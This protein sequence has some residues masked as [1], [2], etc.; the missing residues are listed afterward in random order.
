[1]ERIS[2]PRHPDWQLFDHSEP[3]TAL[4]AGLS[5]GGEWFDHQAAPRNSTT[6]APTARP[7]SC[8]GY[9]A[10]CGVPLDRMTGW[11][12]G[13]K[14]KA[15]KSSVRRTR[16]VGLYTHVQSP[17][18]KGSS[19]SHTPS[20]PGLG[21]YGE[22]LWSFEYSA[23]R[24]P[25]ERDAE[26]DTTTGYCYFGGTSGQPPSTVPLPPVLFLP[27][28]FFLA[29]EDVK[30][31]ASVCRSLR[32][33]AFNR[34]IWQSLCF[35][36]K[37][38]SHPTCPRAGQRRSDGTKS[39]RDVLRLPG[40][41]YTSYACR[42]PPNNSKSRRD[43]NCLR[44]YCPSTQATKQQR[45]LRTIAGEE[46][47][48]S[49]PNSEP[50]YSAWGLRRCEGPSP[51]LY[52]VGRRSWRPKQET[53][54]ESDADMQYEP[55]E[56]GVH[57]GGL[58]VLPGYTLEELVDWRFVF[59]LN[60]MSPGPKIYIR[61][62]DLELQF[63]MH[64]V[65][66]NVA[67]ARRH[68]TGMEASAVQ[69]CACR[70]VEN[71]RQARWG[72]RMHWL[73][74]HE[75]VFIFIRRAMNIRR[76]MRL[77]HLRPGS[78]PGLCVAE[79]IRDQ[80]YLLEWQ[81]PLHCL[82]EP[83][84]H[85]APFAVANGGPASPLVWPLPPY[86]MRERDKECWLD[87][88]SVIY[89]FLGSDQEEP[90]LHAPEADAEYASRP[91][92]AVLDSG[93]AFATL[94]APLSYRTAAVFIALGAFFV[95]VATASATAT[96]TTAAAATATLAARHSRIFRMNLHV[97][98]RDEHEEDQHERTEREASPSCLLP[99][100]S[101]SLA[102]EAVPAPG[103]AYDCH[104][105][106]ANEAMAGRPR[107]HGGSF[108][109]A[110]LNDVC[111]GGH[112]GKRESDHA[113][114]MLPYVQG[115]IPARIARL[116]RSSTLASLA[117]TDA[118]VASAT[119]VLTAISR[120]ALTATCAALAAA[121]AALTAMLLPPGAAVRASA[122]DSQQKGSFVFRVR[123]AGKQWLRHR[124]VR[125][126][127]SL[128]LRLGA[129]AGGNAK[130]STD[131]SFCM[132]S[133]HRFPHEGREQQHRPR[134]P[135]VC[136]LRQ[137]GVSQDSLLDGLSHPTPSQVCEP[138]RILHASTEACPRHSN[139][140]KPIRS[141]D[142]CDAT[143]AFEFTDD[144]E[145]IV[146]RSL[147]DGHKKSP[148]RRSL[149]QRR[150]SS[151]CCPGQKRAGRTCVVSSIEEREE[152][153]RC[154]RMHYGH[155]EECSA[156][157]VSACTGEA[158][159]QS[160]CLC[161]SGWQLE[162]TFSQPC[163]G[164]LLFVNTCLPRVNDV[165]CA[166]GLIGCC[167]S[168]ADWDALTAA[169]SIA[170]REDVPLLLP[171]DAT[172]SDLV[173][174]LFL[175]LAQRNY[176]LPLVAAART[177]APATGSHLCNAAG[178]SVCLR[179]SRR[180]GRSTSAARVPQRAHL[181][182]WLAS[183]Q[184]SGDHNA[185]QPMPSAK[186]IGDLRLM[187][188][189]R[190][191]LTV[192]PS[193][194]GGLSGVAHTR[195]LT[196]V[197]GPEDPVR[198]GEAPRLRRISTG[199]IERGNPLH[200]YSAVVDYSATKSLSSRPAS[201][202]LLPRSV[203]AQYGTLGVVMSNPNETE[204]VLILRREAGPGLLIQ[205]PK[206]RI[207]AHGGHSPVYSTPDDPEITPSFAPLELDSGSANRT[208]CSHF[209]HG[210]CARYSLN[211][212]ATASENRRPG[213]GSER[214]EGLLQSDVKFCKPWILRSSL[215]TRQFEY[216]PQRMNVM[217]TGTNDGT[218]CLLDW[219]KDA[220][221][222][223]KLVDSHQIL[224]LSWL[225]HHP[226]LFV[227]A[228]GVSGIPYVL[229]CTEQDD[230]F[231]SGMET[232]PA[233]APSATLP[234]CLTLP[235][236]HAKYKQSALHQE[237]I[238]EAQCAPDK[239]SYYTWDGE[240]I[241]DGST[242]TAALTWFRHCGRG[243]QM[244]RRDTEP[245]RIVHQYCACEELSS[246]TINSTDDYMLVSGR[247]PDI[248]IHDVATGV[249]L[250]TLSGLHAGS[251]N[252]VRFAHTSPHL[253]VTASFDQTCRL[254]DLRQRISG[255]QPLLNVETGSLSV[256]CCFDDSDEWLLCS[257][258][259]AALRQVCL[260][261]SEVYPESFAIPPVNAETNFRRAVYL[262]GGREFITAGTEEGFF[263][264]FSRCGRDLG[265]VSLEGMLRPFARLRSSQS[266][267]TM[268]ILACD[269]L[270]LRTYLRSHVELGLTAMGGAAVAT[271]AGV[272]RFSMAA[273]LRRAFRHLGGR[274]PEISDTAELLERTRRTVGESQGGLCISREGPMQSLTDM[275]QEDAARGA[276]ERCAVEE[277]VQSLRAHPQE[278]RL[279][280]TLLAAKDQVETAT[281]KLSFVAMSRLPSRMLG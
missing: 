194:F 264:V 70:D 241:F 87:E 169:S 209:Q 124:F 74:P 111:T 27:V 19:V 163:H 242:M 91:F 211:Q 147:S 33:I 139:C 167:G 39:S 57:C 3:I 231:V 215:N 127:A 230:S 132:R 234:S 152:C 76:P 100:V 196:L 204:P 26:F 110:T 279:V 254:W 71:Q 225:K 212:L 253:F 47:W 75:F 140:S 267:P 15:S 159:E 150:T 101:G 14:V 265:V 238:E 88:R 40:Q 61:V 141:A 148:F 268:P 66:P 90:F 138:Q 193:A 201:W 59:L 54:L 113:S 20:F 174:L 240:D 30:S 277:Y 218:V 149:P 195:C 144:S 224:G 78:R 12:M 103:T 251:I 184:P 21:F 245:L 260:R 126:A 9:S 157:G 28:A 170:P 77:R 205:G 46:S 117:L 58:Q 262:Q 272:S 82:L 164:L 137:R 243:G 249:K 281:G 175:T 24:G 189:E 48:S 214:S 80:H 202:S 62:K 86:G 128:R 109:T 10:D 31:L 180:R 107:Q 275:P 106:S 81:V 210:C 177:G 183:T 11:N 65:V 42:R 92:Y 155:H 199:D 219:E 22:P 226:E 38:V 73:S 257:G 97:I 125:L 49:S 108:S 104:G 116:L 206:T 187:S 85:S 56:S 192:L 207:T 171:A 133:L 142:S 5:P 235:T 203:W 259:D 274:P 250:E 188:C 32:W 246:V 25:F 4:Q 93:G 208:P 229:R 280:G 252:I 99:G 178:R 191:S 161:P 43:S 197:C 233:R 261:S 105:Q 84:S 123:R 118:S 7:E 44:S 258:V 67:S 198:H 160:V 181:F 276:A 120:D 68:A 50:V 34:K 64:P 165:T 17:E 220:I 143:T 122:S 239:E 134:Q 270:N 173:R 236:F 263:R 145:R 168:N 98:E 55:D 278:R 96:L 94:M 158:A 156:D 115:L 121:S 217:L 255:H 60:R 269:L 16:K 41:S 129:E 8:V 102:V 244:T 185:E 53:H 2:R 135:Q 52:S 153:S 146:H 83:A 176:M 232:D 45:T 112:P 190:M 23:P 69:G 179:R 213:H 200:P 35:S 36:E 63:P 114:P 151:R 130:E 1:M 37:L 72:T 13:Q 89:S 6:S 222:G 186:L 18:V 162:V 227:C 154:M 271:A 182:F 237:D 248:T 221:L 228:A 119:T 51:P 131:T 166:H 247:S 223:T 256:M 79:I 216:H 136:K 29:A 95:A 172:V 266:L 273:A